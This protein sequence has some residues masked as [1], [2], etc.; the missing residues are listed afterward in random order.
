MYLIE[1]SL[2]LREENYFSCFMVTHLG[3]HVTFTRSIYNSKYASGRSQNGGMYLV[4]EAQAFQKH[5]LWVSISRIID[6]HFWLPNHPKLFGSLTSYHE[7]I[8]TC[9][10][11]H[12]KLTHNL[13]YMQRNFQVAA[14]LSHWNVYKFANSC[15][16]VMNL[17]SKIK[18]SNPEQKQIELFMASFVELHL[19]V[20]GKGLL[21]VAPLFL[22]TYHRIYNVKVFFIIL[23][24]CCKHWPYWLCTWGGASSLT[25]TLISQSAL[26]ALTSALTLV[27]LALCVKCRRSLKETLINFS[28]NNNN[29]I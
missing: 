25:K 20:P 3:L 13:A 21:F 23:W 7:L 29:F 10:K 24:H 12:V 18:A 11:A 5:I 16:I 28:L 8:L 4:T 2:F 19:F 1:N 14:T 6:R 26:C 27:T 17:R 22:Q 15:T 9:F